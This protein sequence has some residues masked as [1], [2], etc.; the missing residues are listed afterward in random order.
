MLTHK[1]LQANRANANRS[2][3]NALK[4][5]TGV[6]SL[7]L[8]WEDPAG[9][10]A[11]RAEGYAAHR[12]YAPE[13]RPASLNPECALGQAFFSG[14]PQPAPSTAASTPIIAPSTAIRAAQRMWIGGDFEER[15]QFRG[16]RFRPGVHL[17]PC[18]LEASWA[19]R[20][21]AWLA[22]W[23]FEGTKPISWFHF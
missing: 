20:W 12:P 15:S 16:F 14:S 3:R 10:V 8:H 17:P 19:P 21:A 7:T 13:E 18:V 2:S 23:N 22:A 11:L 5:G 4:S 9:H 1:Q 6:Q